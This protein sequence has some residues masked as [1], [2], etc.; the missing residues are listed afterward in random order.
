MDKAAVRNVLGPASHHELASR[1]SSKM[2]VDS[3]FAQCLKVMTVRERSFQFHTEIGR[4]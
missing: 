4:H 1:P 3:L 2:R